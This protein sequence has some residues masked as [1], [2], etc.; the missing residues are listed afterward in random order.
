MAGDGF[1]G[2]EAESVAY[3]SFTRQIPV[4]VAKNC[5]LSQLYA[6]KPCE[7]CE[8]LSPITV[9][10]DKFLWELRKSVAYHSYTRQ[11]PVRAAKHCRLS[12]LY[13]T[14]PCGSCEK[15][16][17]ITAIRDKTL[18]ELRKSVAYLSYTRQNPVGAAK[19][20]R[21]SQLYA[22]KPCESCEK[23]SPITALYATKPCESYEKL[24]PITA[25]RDKTLWELRN[26][27]AYHSFTRQ[28]P[29]RA[30]KHCRLSQL[31]AT[32]PYESCETLSPISTIRDKFL[33]NL[34]K[35]VAYHSF[36]R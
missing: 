10:R 6:T 8:K 5:R 9:L 27:V 19:N 25:L 22:T 12:Q 7:S 21:L 14:K 4:R 24:S 34:R 26:I 17:P 36:T 20:C 3:H 1:F 31:Y 32:K 16:S 15:L 18:W 29:M 33:W 23:L 11:N 30:A 35:S 13:A 2:E 28:N